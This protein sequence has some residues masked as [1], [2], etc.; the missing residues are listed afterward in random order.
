VLTVTVPALALGGPDI[1]TK[2]VNRSSWVYFAM[3]SGVEDLVPGAA[4][5]KVTGLLQEATVD[6]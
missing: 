4:H 5:A 1:A 2:R 6:I 3:T